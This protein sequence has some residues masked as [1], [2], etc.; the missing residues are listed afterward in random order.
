MSKSSSWCVTN[1]SFYLNRKSFVLEI[2]WFLCS[3]NPQILKSV[4][5]VTAL[6]HN[7]SYTYAYLFRIL[8]AIEMKF[9]QVLARCMKNISNMF[10]T[11]CWRLETSSWTFYDFIKM[12]IQ[13][14]LTIFNSWHLPFLIVSYLHF[15]KNETLESW[16]SWLLSNLSK[17]L[18]WKGPGT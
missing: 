11:Q 17:L 8:S 18:N 13:Q 7:G 9:G 4:T 16:L 2:F 6:L 3:W 15:Q 12:T 10:L 5:S 14:A 1:E